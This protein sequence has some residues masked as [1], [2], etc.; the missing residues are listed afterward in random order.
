MMYTTVLSHPKIA[1]DVLKL[2]GDMA[3]WMDEPPIF[4]PE[5]KATRPERRAYRERS[6]KPWQR[7]IQRGNRP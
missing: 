3:E 6:L 7:C 2:L 4:T 1:Q 5:E